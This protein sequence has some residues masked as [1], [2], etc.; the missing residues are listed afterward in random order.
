[1]TAARPAA[2]LWITAERRGEN[3]AR[4]SQTHSTRAQPCRSRRTC[5]HIP[6]ESLRERER[7]KH[8]WMRGTWFRPAWNA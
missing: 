1:M 2:P 8:C 3:K 6:A 4:Q 5:N 7:H